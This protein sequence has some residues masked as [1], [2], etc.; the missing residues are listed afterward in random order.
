LRLPFGHI[1][2][3]QR[4]GIAGLKGLEV[5][6]AI[7]EKLHAD[8]IDVIGAAP[9]RHV[10]A[11]IIRIALERDVAPRLKAVD[12]VRGRGNRDH[13]DA[14]LGKIN[15]LPLRLFQDRA[16]A[17]DQRQLAVRHIEG[18]PDFARTGDLGLGDLAPGAVI[19]RMTFQR[20]AP[21]RAG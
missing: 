10:F 9:K 5:R 4:I 2:L 6:G 13:I 15:P 16:Q 21:L 18:K 3:A 11:P 12:H 14:A 8:F 20:I 7:G 1:S 17:H 19:A